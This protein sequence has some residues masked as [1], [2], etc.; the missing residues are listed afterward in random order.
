MTILSGI[1]L[2]FLIWWTLIFTVLPWRATP[3]KQ[4]LTG[5]AASAPD[6]ANIKLKFLINTVLSAAVWL[7]L[8]L[9]THFNILPF[10]QWAEMMG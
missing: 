7:V 2:Y 6:K 9:L 8:F 5:N 4:P 10:R 3:S 1:I